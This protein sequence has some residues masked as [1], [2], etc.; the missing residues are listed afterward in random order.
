MSKD[1]EK[2]VEWLNEG[3]SMS[4]IGR[5]LG[6]PV[7]NISAYCK[8]HGLKSSHK[9]TPVKEI[10]LQ[11]VYDK[12]IKGVSMYK[13]SNEYGLPPQTL[14]RKLLKIK[15]IEIRNMD[16]AKRHSSLNS[17]ERLSELMAAM[18]LRAIASKL[19]TRPSTVC[20]AVKRLG[21]SSEVR[22]TIHNIPTEEFISLYV[23]HEISLTDIALFYHTYPSS[24][25]KRRKSA[26]V[27]IR[28]PGHRGSKIELFNSKEAL[29]D[30][31]ITQER[32]LSYIATLAGVCIATVIH[33][34]KRF[35]IKRRSKSQDNRLRLQ[36]QTEDKNIKIDSKWGT[37]K[38]KS[39]QERDFIAS[40]P[41]SVVSLKYE[42]EELLHKGRF[43]VPDFKVDGEFVE[44]KPVEWGK[45]SGVN[46][47]KFAHQLQIANKNNVPLKTWYDGKYY[48]HDTIG[49]DD[50][51]YAIDWRLFFDSFND[52]F[53]F[54]KSRGW[55]HPL[56]PND[57]MI[58]GVTGWMN[59]PEVS[60]FNANVSKPKT[61]NLMRH[62]HKNYYH[63]FRKD[64]LPVTAAFEEGNYN[65]LLSALEYLWG[66]PNS[67][68]IYG[69]INTISSRYRDFAMVSMFKPWVARAVY[70]KFLPNGGVIVDPCCGWGG[71]MIAC[72]ESE[73]S[74]VGSDINNS[75]IEANR[76][77]ADY[78]GNHYINKPVLKQQDATIH[79]DQ[80][81]LLFTSP[82]YDDTERYY[83]I[84]SASIKSEYIYENIFKQFNGTVALNIPVRHERLVK[85]VASKYRWNLYDEMSMSTRAI[86]SMGPTTE[87]ILV[88]KR[89]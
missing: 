47:R 85:S 51:F 73:Y 64:C 19:G 37:F 40:V 59:V 70:E 52:C 23:D 38:L 43:Y 42:S 26:G 17:V 12:Y 20:A 82:P 13:L 79:I 50:M 84:D 27:I 25:C 66:K 77:M 80:G 78:I 30:L 11:E 76:S 22:R 2:I 72:M 67:C 35:D 89:A 24:I 55:V 62:F 74:Y 6:K 16:Q 31:Y 33:H 10:N 83:G 14:K 44:V 5:R 21:L 63:S 32:S 48:D 71:R 69:L 81:D 54:L 46:R 65:V 36:R 1:H 8:R 57:M 68:N 3:L 75:N 41:D 45:I 28:K 86:V 15:D 9:P 87:P 29:H 60:K 34:L 18:S 61:I 39:K 7:S 88:F 56:Y 49:K 58:L 53:S 4:E